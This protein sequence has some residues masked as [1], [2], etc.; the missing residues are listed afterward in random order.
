[1]RVLVL[2][3]HYSA[4]GFTHTFHRPGYEWDVG[5]HYIGDVRPGSMLGALFDDIGDGTLEW[6]DLGEVYDRV[7]LGE[8]RFDFRRGSENLRADLIDRFP[9]ESGAIDDYFEL[10]GEVGASTWRF[11]MEKA[12]P[13]P[14]AAVAGPFLRRRFLKHARG[15]TRD[16]LESLTTDQRLIGIL[17]TQWGDYGLPPDR[18]SFGIHALVAGHYLEGAFYP[19]GGAARIA[20]S[21]LPVIAAAGGTVLVRADVA[22]I[23]VESGRVA[24]VRMASDGAIL[25]APLV[26]SDAGVSNTFRQLLPRDVAR[27]VGVLDRL[28]DLEASIGHHCLYVGLARTAG[29]L[30]LPRANLWVYPDE[31]HERTYTAMADAD[32]DRRLLYISFPSA[33]D[34]DFTRRHPGRATIDIITRASPDLFTRWD[35]TRWKKRGQAYDA[36]KERVANALLDALYEHVPQTRGKVDTWELSTPLT[37]RHFSN[38]PSGEIYG[39]A[40]TPRRFE[41]RWLRPRTRL[42]GLYLTGQDIVTAGVAGALM[43]GALCASAILGRN[44]VGKVARARGASRG[45]GRVPASGAGE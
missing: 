36:M 38:H 29:E 19:V 3:R 24:G 32:P 17:T 45:L 22:G 5:V 37:T 11:F 7:V 26:I 10:L 9:S 33:K 16:V 43:G 41:Q 18:S 42:P 6:A 30:G 1:L 20:E 27:A 35:G 40:H 12:L 39:L 13:S 25:R 23:V 8:E 21:I 44:L 2:E 28:E 34:P 14:V 31:D 4:G 15:T